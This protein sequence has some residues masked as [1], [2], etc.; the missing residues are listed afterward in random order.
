MGFDNGHFIPWYRNY[1]PHRNFTTFN[2]ALLLVMRM[3]S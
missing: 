1:K 3:P 2:A